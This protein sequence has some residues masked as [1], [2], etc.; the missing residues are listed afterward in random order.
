MVGAALALAAC[1]G[2]DG[3]AATGASAATTT[4][5]T[6][7]SA[8]TS[9]APDPSAGPMPATTGTGPTTPA[10]NAPTVPATATAPAGGPKLL[11]VPR[12]F[13]SEGQTWT[14]RATDIISSCAEHATGRATAYLTAHPCRQASRTI[15]TTTTGGRGVVVTRSVVVL[16]NAKPSS[17]T[18]GTA[19]GFLALVQEGRGDLRDLFQEGV[20]YPGGPAGMPTSAV[21]GAVRQDV[22]VVVVRAAYTTGTTTPSD[23]AL[24]KVVAAAYN[25]QTTAQ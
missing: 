24:S 18:F 14:N 23:P 13:S 9:A 7:T 15:T 11:P 20:R 25:L 16:P 3:T 19:D 1:S 6:T 10:S 5:A 8:E 2:S 21:L 22:A 12:P 4:S 17:D